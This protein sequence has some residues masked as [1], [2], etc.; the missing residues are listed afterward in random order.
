MWRAALKSISG[1]KSSSMAESHGGESQRE[2]YGGG[3]GGWHGVAGA[4][5]KQ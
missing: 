1:E 2:E 4:G 3:I 5:E